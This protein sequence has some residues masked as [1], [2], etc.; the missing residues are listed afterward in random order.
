MKQYVYSRVPAYAWT[1]SQITH[2]DLMALVPS[3]RG[4][5][6]LEDRRGGRVFTV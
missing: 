2:R 5:E 1:S 4:T 3:A 6:R